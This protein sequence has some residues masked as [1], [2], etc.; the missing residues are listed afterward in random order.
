MRKGTAVGVL[1]T[2]R[3]NFD[4][5]A[6]SGVS[7]GHQGVPLDVI[8]V[9][10]LTASFRECTILIVDEFLKM[11]QVPDDLVM[12]G[13]E[14]I[15]AVFTSLGEIYGITP[16]ILLCSEFMKEKEYEKIYSEIYD[17]VNSDRELEQRI[18]ETIP[19]SKR[20]LPNARE[21]PLHEFAC[22]MYLEKHRGI[23]L[24]IGPTTEI[25]YDQIMEKLG[26]NVNYAYFQEAIALGTGDHISSVIHYLPTSR[27]EYNGQRIFFEDEPRIVQ[28]KLE[29]G[30][31]TALLYFHRLGYLCGKLLGK[32]SASPEEVENLRE[33]A[34]RKKTIGIVLENIILPLK[35]V[36]A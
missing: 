32:D 6:F 26:I 5:K 28:R 15:R 4:V 3:D 16:E 35:K 17:P 23:K 8:A 11:N 20:G 2:A 14:N 19:L 7:Y 31:K 22:V 36:G 34:L 30:N 1:S 27:G 9:Y 33:H 12:S 29:Q 25:K 24:K 18:L 10:L 21:Y 13:R